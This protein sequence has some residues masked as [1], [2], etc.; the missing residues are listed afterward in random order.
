M[1]GFYNV[2]NETYTS[3]EKLSRQSDKRRTRQPI[4]KAPT[5]HSIAA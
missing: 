2:L 4:F 3:L 1:F 5:A